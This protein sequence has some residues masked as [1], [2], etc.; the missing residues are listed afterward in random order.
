MHLDRRG[1]RLVILGEIRDLDTGDAPVHDGVR[2]GLELDVHGERLQGGA[3][4]DLV[5]KAQVGQDDHP[6]C[7]SLRGALKRRRQEGAGLGGHGVRR[8][9]SGRVRPERDHVPPRRAELVDPCRGT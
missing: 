3:D 8:V 7:A 6:P 2:E 5:L 4:R 9:G 1:D